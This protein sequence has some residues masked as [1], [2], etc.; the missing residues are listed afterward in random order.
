MKKTIY[1]I[2][3][4]AAILTGCNREIFQPEG[5]GEMILDLSCSSEYNAAGTKA[6][7][8]EDI[9]N[10]LS[11]KIV[12]PADGWTK[13]FEPFSSIKGTVISLGSGD[14][15]ITASSPE[16]EDAAFDLPYLEGTK[17]FTISTG[18]VT[19]VSMVCKV[20]NVKIS[21]NLSENFTTEL[22]DYTVTV[23][24]GK[25]YLTW[26]KNG[27]QTDFK[28]VIIEGKT[29]YT[30]IKAGYFSVAPLTVQV[31]GHRS[32]DNSSAS[33]TYYINDPTAAD[34]HILNLDAN[35]TGTLEGITITIDDSVND[36][37]NSVVVPGFD[38]D[39]VEGDETETDPDPTPDPTPDPEPEPSTAPYMVW[40]ANP[41]FAPMNI[42]KNLNANLIVKAPEKIATFKVEVNSPNLGPAITKLTSDGSTTM[43]LIG[44][45][46]L[47]GKLAV[48]AKT[49]PTGDKLLG[50]TSVDFFLTS[51]VQMISMY[52]PAAGTQHHFTLI[53][54][55][56]KDQ[57]MSQKVTFVSVEEATE[58]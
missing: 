45:Q 5:K 34:H 29:I 47:I 30:G 49:L 21:V 41:S 1:T 7:S 25:G 16:K 14:Y 18:Q 58:E 43:D 26:Q 3:A 38:E 51:L 32:L 40:E 28:P 37:E 22:T 11:V 46:K 31:N 10:G 36:I 19:S 33:I 57:I 20:A 4:A 53:V 44:D 23:T 55:D 52:S 24:N 12:R 8:D 2:L 42:D 56:E 15:T 54:K 13:T 6:S 27:T 17:D 9:V 48:M 50:Q 39:P 35:V